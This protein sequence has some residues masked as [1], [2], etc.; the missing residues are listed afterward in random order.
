M[1][2]ENQ[3]VAPGQSLALALSHQLPLLSVE[4]VRLVLQLS[5]Y[6]KG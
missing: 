1:V 3:I 4:G 6:L 2:K 5:Y